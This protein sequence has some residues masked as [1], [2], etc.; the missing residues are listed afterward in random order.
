MLLAFAF[1]AVVG[2]C[3]SGGS[4]ANSES[5]APTEAPAAEPSEPSEKVAKAKP[6][7]S[8]Y[9]QSEKRKRALDSGAQ[10]AIFAGGCFWGVEHYFEI[11]PGVLSVT[12]GYAGGKGARPSYKDVSSGSSGHAEVVEVLYDSKT[13]NF[14]KLARLFF[15][16]HDPTQKDRQGPDVGTQYRSAVFYQDAEQRKTAE[17]LVALLKGKGLAVVTELAPAATFWPAED[18]HQDYYARTGGE[19]YCHSRVKRF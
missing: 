1:V 5:T 3:R 16:I 9:T 12:S 11:E 4:D 19:P 2:G 8:E 6:S 14:E 10:S 15:E 7:R 17:R 13:T 18:Y